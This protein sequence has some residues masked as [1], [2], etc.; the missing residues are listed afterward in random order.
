MK[1]LIM[2]YPLAFMA[3]GGTLILVVGVAAGWW[4]KK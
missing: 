2:T 3:A 1:D 4:R